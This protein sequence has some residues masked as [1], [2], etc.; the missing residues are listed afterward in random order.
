[1]SADA[2]LLCALLAD[3]ARALEISDHQWPA[4]LTIAHAERLAGS[5]AYRLAGLAL[6]APV[7][8]VLDAAR[9]QAATNRTQMLWEAEMARRALAPLDVRVVLLKGAAYGAA[10]LE[11]AQGRQIGDLDILVPHDRLDDVEAALLEAGWQWV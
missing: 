5:L 6:P 4:L 7:Q 9:L 2:R 8:S 10:G 3:P 11:T 1:M